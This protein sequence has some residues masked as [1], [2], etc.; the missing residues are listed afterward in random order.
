M[1]NLSEQTTH[2]IR[3]RRTIK[4]KMFSDQ[5]VPE[6]IV[7][8]MLENANWAPTHGMTE[9]WRFHVYVAAARKRLGEFLSKTY[10]DICPPDAY[11]QKKFDGMRENP[12]LAPVVIAIG[13]K[14]QPI[15][16]ITEL[17]EIL[18]I[19]CAV[20]NL[21]L[22]AAARG[23]GGFWSTNI[24]ATSDQMRDFMGLGANDRAMGL[25][26]IGYPKADWPTS[27]RTP[28]TEKVQWVRD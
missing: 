26:Y 1:N 8:E 15:Q 19:G 11:K 7:D 16:K 24:A 2:I 18:A 10:K 17:D 4:P 9:P 23:L 21:H 22:S 20:Q 14:R 25:F 3:H 6:S 27:Q 13:M 28:T 5:S 12:T